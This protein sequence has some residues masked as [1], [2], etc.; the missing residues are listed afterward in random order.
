MNSTKISNGVS[1]S[2]NRAGHCPENS[3]QASG[4]V[5]TPIDCKRDTPRHTDDTGERQSDRLL[6]IFNE[7]WQ[8]TVTR[9]KWPLQSQL[10]REKIGYAEQCNTAIPI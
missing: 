5:D 9:D 1:P 3:Q 4:H 2:V 8:F 6:F 7:S 10:G